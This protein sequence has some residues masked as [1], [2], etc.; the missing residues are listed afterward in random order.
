MDSGGSTLE[1][2]ILIFLI[3]LNGVF[4]MVEIALVAS[5]HTRL[6]VLSQEGDQRAKSVLAEQEEPTRALSTIQVGIT[7]I[8]VLS[9]IV[10]EAA[11]AGPIAH[12]LMTALNFPASSA[13]WVSVALIVVGVTYFSIVFG[14]LVP[15]RLGQ[16]YPEKIACRF[17]GPL[18]ALA[19][20]MAPFVKLLSSSTDCVLRCVGVRGAHDDTVTEEE[21]HAMIDEGSETG[22]IEENERDMVRNVFRLDD[23]Q[24]GS[25]MT[26]RS[27][28]EW[29][30][31]ADSEETNIAKI[32]SSSRSRLIAAEGNLN[33]VRGYC[34]TKALLRQIIEGK[35]PR[36]EEGL[37]PVA[38]VPETMTGLEL[39][40]HFK[41]TNA[42]L[43]LVID[44]Y[45]EVVG[46]VSPRDIF[47]AIAGEFKPSANEEFEAVKR[48]D[49]AWILDG[50][51]AVPE[52]KD[53]LQLKEL[54]DEENARYDTLSGMMMFLLERVPKKGDVVIWGDW[55]FEVV[56][57]EGLHIDR[58]VAT[59]I[60][61][62]NVTAQ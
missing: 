53:K 20:V 1:I 60:K 35:V 44:E 13:R 18:R 47:E 36:I 11:L 55:R 45:G 9:G 23:R 43:S 51:I 62:K 49:G 59:N 10:G 61:M 22:V 17:V 54:P 48:K 14:E 6:N 29:I 24:L 41:A 7:S 5:R 27:D 37:L 25:V 52:L 32:I 2:V 58:V 56:Q 16:E 34:T 4:A 31:L 33:N 40:E 30:N 15:K 26:P 57:M 50:F 21:I 39:L 42:A 38:F 12:W 8:G 28:I 19:Y 46:L 3:A